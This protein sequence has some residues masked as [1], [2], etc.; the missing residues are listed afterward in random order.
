MSIT[1]II[2]G[3][4]AALLSLVI[5][6]VLGRQRQQIGTAAKLLDEQADRAESKATEMR[7]QATVELAVEP[8]K[9]VA[10]QAAVTASV[11]AT[12]NPVDPYGADPFES[13][14]RGGK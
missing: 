12:A 10:E 14:K 3:A 11:A 4:F 9:L 13:Y 5:G 7:E 2:V 1:S 8:A 6:L